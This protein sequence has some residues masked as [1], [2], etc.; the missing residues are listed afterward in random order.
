MQWRLIPRGTVTDSKWILSHGDEHLG[1]V[2][3]LI[4]G[5]WFSFCAV[6]GEFDFGDN[7]EDAK[8]WLELEAVH[9][10]AREICEGEL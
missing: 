5:G 4:S 1:S 7:L 6:T 10:I 9:A 3:F 2:A 8:R